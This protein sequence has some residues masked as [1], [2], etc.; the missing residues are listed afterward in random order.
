MA[1][2]G[3]ASSRMAQVQVP[4]IPEIGALIRAHPGTISLGQGIV[5]YGPPPRSKK[6]LEDFWKNP[7]NHGYAAVDGI[8][9]LQD[10]I[11]QKLLSDNGIEVT[12]KQAIVVTAGANMGF[13]HALLAVTEPGEEVIL[14]TPYYFNH[15]M[16]I[17]MLGCVPVCVPLTQN[18]EID[19]ELIEKHITGR[20]KAIVTV[21]P[22]NPTGAVV[23]P[24]TLT[25]INNL[26]GERGIYHISDEAYEY[27][28][29]DEVEHFSPGKNPLSKNYTISLYS[30]SKA[31]GFAGWRIGYMVVP[32]HLALAVSKAQDTNLICPSIP[33]QYAAIGAMEEGAEYPRSHL[34]AYKR[35]RDQIL[36][37]LG[38]LGSAFTIKRPEG[39]FYIMIQL[40]GEHDSL[41][42]AKAL[43]TSHRVAVIPGT[44][45]G[46]HNTCSLRISYG[47]LQED[48]VLE[49]VGRLVD[50]LH[51]Y[52]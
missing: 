45:F 22:N 50:G 34:A 48:T 35:V 24:G 6:R 52:R 46:L 30:L 18:N 11:R 14:F 12:D 1:L 38:S 27:F 13:L 40:H 32:K 5:H 39:A 49:G 36:K 4:I 25:H 33:S 37:V 9:E 7:K 21:S 17:S 42:I 43:I 8:P 44:A 29:Y 41:H 23:S 2:F 28:V 20:T 31:Y 19:V 47:S 16:A 3:M 26:C 10:I 15:E 51:A